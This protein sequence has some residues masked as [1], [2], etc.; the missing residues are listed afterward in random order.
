M[1]CVCGMLFGLY[2]GLPNVYFSLV[3]R[4]VFA[5]AFVVHLQLFPYVHDV[6]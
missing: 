4:P 2:G 5:W 3:W 1:C 6:L